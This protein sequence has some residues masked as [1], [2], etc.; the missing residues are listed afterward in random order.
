[1]FDDGTSEEFDLVVGADGIKSRIRELVFG[2]AS[3]RYS[4]IRIQF[5]EPVRTY[6]AAAHRALMLAS[7]ECGLSVALSPPGLSIIVDDGEPGVQ[8]YVLPGKGRVLPRIGRKY[9]SGLGMALTA[10]CTLVRAPIRFNSRLLN[11]RRFCRGHRSRDRPPCRE[12]GGRC[13]GHGGAGA[14]GGFQCGREFELGHF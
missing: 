1:M 7:H 6:L 3:P 2:A 14:P 4:N 11:G 12:Q 13:T 8:A 9:I 10:W 5:G